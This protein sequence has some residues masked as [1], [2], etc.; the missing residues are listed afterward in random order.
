MIHDVEIVQYIKM[1]MLKDIEKSMND[2]NITQ[3]PTTMVILTQNNITSKYYN[4]EKMMT[5]GPNTESI[6]SVISNNFDNIKYVE[7]QYPWCNKPKIYNKEDYIVQVKEKYKIDVLKPLLTIQAC[8]G[9]DGNIKHI[10]KN[11]LDI[12]FIKQV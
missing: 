12:E 8:N 11:Y 9:I 3:E 10:I 7:F 4:I 2:C 5:W 1:K 6:L